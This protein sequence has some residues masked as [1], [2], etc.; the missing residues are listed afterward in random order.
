LIYYVFTVKT[1]KQSDDEK[2]IDYLNID[3]HIK[4]LNGVTELTPYACGYD[5]LILTSPVI[6][7]NICSLHG[8]NLWN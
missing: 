3:T 1:E 7:P 6:Y 8:T 2:K 4:N 5:V